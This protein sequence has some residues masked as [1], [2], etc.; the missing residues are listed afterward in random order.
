MRF[1]GLFAAGN[2]SGPNAASGYDIDDYILVEY[3]VDDGP[4]VGGL[5]FGFVVA[6][7]QIIQELHGTGFDEPLAHDTNFDGNGDGEVLHS[8][9]TPFSFDL[10]NAST[11]VLKITVSM[12]QGSEEVAFDGFRLTGIQTGAASVDCNTNGVPDECEADCNTNGV[13]DACDLAG[14]A[15]DSDGDGVLD[16]CESS[17]PCDPASNSMCPWADV[18]CNDVV[19]GL[20]I[21]VIANSCN[22]GFETHSAAVPR[23]DVNGDG[24]VNGL[25]LASASSSACFGQ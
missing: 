22:F 8:L 10:P 12:T 1:T 13:A 7:P 2:M 17:G 20:D 9:L 4:F 25:D 24:I 6:Q 18:D 23:A 14:G 21:S 3:S 15:C 19:N 5:R 16:A 11:V